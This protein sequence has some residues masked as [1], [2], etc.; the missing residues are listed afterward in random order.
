MAYIELSQSHF[1]HNLE[2]IAAHAGGKERVAI[3]L[4]D[5]AYGHGLQEMAQM[6]TEFGL[7]HAVVRTLKEAE[8]IALHFETILVLADTPVVKV[9]DNIHITINDLE[10]LSKLLPQT[11]VELKVDSGMHRNGITPDQLE[12]ALQQIQQSQLQLAG[13][14]THHRSADTLSSEFYW[15]A[16]QYEEI[17]TQVRSFCETRKLPLPRF[18]SCNSAALFRTHKFDESIA[19]VGIAA[20][21]LLRMQTPLMQP[22]LKPVMTLWTQKLHTF[23]AKPGRG[24]GYNGKGSVAKTQKAGVYD[25]G[26]GDGLLRLRDD[27][28]YVSEEGVEI[29]GRVSMDNII[30]SSDKPALPLFNDANRYADAAQ[31]ISYEVTTRLHPEIERKISK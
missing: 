17:K 19:R 7:K 9:P 2:T 23:E 27:Q 25:V 8:Q 1:F 6:A 18:H 31:T 4:K 26:Y 11:K 21:G 13:V 20:Y 15:Q 22:E 12:S 30:L 16:K 10:H 28:S 5:N 29:L 3:V 24:M 14:F